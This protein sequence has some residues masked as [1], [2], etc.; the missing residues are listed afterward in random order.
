VSVN[1]DYLIG[2]LPLPHSGPRHRD[3]AVS[4]S[5]ARDYPGLIAVLTRRTGDPQLASDLLQDA[6]VTTLAK[7]GGGALP[8]EI[9][10]GYVFRTAI[11]HLRNHQRRERDRTTD[12]DIDTFEA[13]NSESPQEASQRD[14]NQ[15]LVRRLLDEL[16]SSRDRRVLVKFYFEECAREEICAELQISEAQFARIIHR[17][18]TRMRQ[19]ME[20]AGYRRSDL[21]S[22]LLLLAPV[23]LG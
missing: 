14:A 1:S 5:L 3:A 17:A 13:E 16:G 15:L 12:R 8:Q 20:R 19:L 21:L 22:A 23:L 18:R 6:I 10:A 4:H 2:N 9:F 7:Q 11:N